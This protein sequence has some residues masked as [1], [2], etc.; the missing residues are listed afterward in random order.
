[1]TV[2][3]N[4][5]PRWR[6]SSIGET[7]K[8]AAQSVA[9]RA[10]TLREMTLD[11]IEQAPATGEAVYAKLSEQGVACV[12]YS[13]KPRLS[14]L[15]RQGLVTDS[16]M[17]GMS[18]SGK[19]RSIVWRATTAAERAAFR[20]AQAAQAAETGKKLAPTEPRD[21]I[22]MIEAAGY[23]VT[24]LDER[25]SHY[26]IKVQGHGWFD[27]W[28]STGS[29]RESPRPGGVRGSGGSGLPGLLSA[30]QSVT[31]AKAGVNA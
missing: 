21:T 1:M 10:Q 22:S 6:R 9:P 5:H 27:Y 31:A 28:P 13:I 19:C 8:E 15:S 12:L 2:I 18:D 24:L 14:E 16:G 17:R 3:E 7:A 26:R 30:L 4:T 23:R 29:W 11:L 20:E 25:S